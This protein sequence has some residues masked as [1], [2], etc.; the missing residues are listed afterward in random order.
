MTSYGRSFGW[1]EGNGRCFLIP[2]RLISRSCN[3]VDTE[4]VYLFGA[5]NWICFP[6]LKLGNSRGLWLDQ[7]EFLSSDTSEV[8]HSWCCVGNEQEEFTDCERRLCPSKDEG[9]KSALNV[10]IRLPDFT[11]PCRLQCKTLPILSN[12]ISIHSDCFHSH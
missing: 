3:S 12:I 4:V 2:P 1:K 7:A 6:C 10:Y 9:R 8:S 11:V 5:R